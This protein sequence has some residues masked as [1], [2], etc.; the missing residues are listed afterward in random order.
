M[1]N[2]SQSRMQRRQTKKSKK[3]KK[4]KL[5]W[6]KILLILGIIMSIFFIGIIGVFAYYV[7]GA[8]DIDPEQLSD[9]LSSK[10]Y[11]R[12]GELIVDLGVQQRTKISYNDIPKV[13]EDAVIA[14]ED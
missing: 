4:S 2:N 10:I 3:N 12:N 8:P 13:L 9:P 7:S 1:A 11:D 5:N 14:T 6:K